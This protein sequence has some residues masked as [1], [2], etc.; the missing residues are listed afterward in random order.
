MSYYP[1]WYLKFSCSFNI[2]LGSFKTHKKLTQN[3]A[4]YAATRLRWINIIKKLLKQ[5][6]HK[7]IVKMRKIL[8][9]NFFS[10]AIWIILWQFGKFNVEIT[11]RKIVEFPFELF[12]GKP[13][14]NFWVVLNWNFYW[15]FIMLDFFERENLAGK[16]EN[17]NEKL[18][19]T[20]QLGKDILNFEE[21]SNSLSFVKIF[22][23]IFI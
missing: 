15:S 5:F 1:T 10:K 7:L 14:L 6:L 22:L 13:Q 2:F 11:F 8:F 19:E 20:F 23:K 16:L 9:T 17:L 3:L 4:F 18:D 21:K 12:T